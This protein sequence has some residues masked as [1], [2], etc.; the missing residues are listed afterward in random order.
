MIDEI[1]HYLGPLGVEGEAGERV[2][3]GPHR[4]LLEPVEAA[5]VDIHLTSPSYHKRECLRP[6]N[7]VGTRIGQIIEKAK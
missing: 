7:T 4:H 6:G 5:V 1:E 3:A 2:A